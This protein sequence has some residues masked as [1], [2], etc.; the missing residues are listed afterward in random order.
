MEQINL[1]LIPGKTLPV[2]HVSQYDVG[3]II[4][5]NLFENS[6]VISFAGTETAEVHIRKPD[7]TVVTEPLTVTALATYVEVVT[8]QQMTACAGQNLGEIQITSGTNVIGTINFIMEVE[9]DPLAE[10]IDS[11]SEIYDL[12]AQVSRDVSASV[13]DLVRFRPYG[14]PPYM[15]SLF[16]PLTNIFSGFDNYISGAYY[17]ATPAVVGKPLTITPTA[18]WQ[19]WLVRV[20]PNT[21]YTIGPHDFRILFYNNSLI[22]DKVINQADISSTDPNTITS[23]SDSFWMAITQRITRDMSEWMMVEGNAYPDSYVSGVPQWV[24]MPKIADDQMTMTAVHYSNVPIAVAYNESGVTLTIPAGRVL[25]PKGALIA[26]AGTLTFSAANWVSYDMTADAWT[27]SQHIDGHELYTIGWVNP[28]IT[29]AVLLANYSETGLPDDKNFREWGMVYC[30]HLN[31]PKIKYTSTGC[32]L[33]L[34]TCRVI[35]DGGSFVASATTLTFTASN[36]L[37]Y[38]VDAQEYH[39]GYSVPDHTLIVLGII[40]TSKYENSFIAGTEIMVEKTIAFF[41]DSICAGVGTSKVFHQYISER[42]GFRCL[43][44]GYGGSGYVQ[45]YES[46]GAGRM[47]TGNEGL[48]VP[49]TA[50]NYFV[51]NN[52]LTRLAEPTPSDLDGVVIFAG[53]NDW[54]HAGQI[55]LQQFIDGLEAVFN[56]FQ[57]NFGAVPLLVMTPIHRKDDTVVNAAGKTLREY[58]DIIIDECKKFGIPYVDTMTFSGLHPDNAGNDAIFFPR[59]DRNPPSSDGLHPNHIAHERIMRVIGETLNALVKYDVT[60]MR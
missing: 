5:F 26:Q 31:V 37:T 10:G 44:Y 51:P 50:D 30:G 49:I 23:G 22:V 42:Y 41:G 32:T 28:T 56:Y 21:T 60:A 4:K 2:C 57:T 20:K 36:W 18:N 29:K 7:N 53:T 46:Y 45:N 40:S 6:E 43:N 54:S 1:N 8:T 48:G 19:G 52:V 38:D 25:T 15:M 59:D 13:A 11:D 3:R 14:I 16:K 24:H 55:T 9:A 27:P 39:L 35:Y 58:C 34:P 12:A 33:T 17:T 47:G